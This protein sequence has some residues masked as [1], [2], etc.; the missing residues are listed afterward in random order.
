MFNLEK[1]AK[2]ILLISML[3]GLNIADYLLP[4]KKDKSKR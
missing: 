3:F 2:L 1:Y 4:G